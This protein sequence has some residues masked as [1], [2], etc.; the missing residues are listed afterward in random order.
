VDATRQPLV[1]TA[2]TTSE[3]PPTERFVIRVWLP[4]RPGALGAVASRIGAVGGDVTG[5]EIV[6]QGGGCAV[7][8]LAVELPSRQLDLTL[9][10]IR[11]VDE[12]RVESVRAI[13]SPPLDPRLGPLEAC[14]AAFEART[15]QQLAETLCEHSQLL[16]NG[17][18]A[19]VVC[20]TDGSVVAVRGDSPP[21][22]WLG[23]YALGAPR[24]P[25]PQDPLGGE[26]EVVCSHLGETGRT[27]V[28][29]RATTPLRQREAEIVDALTLV[30]TARW[31]EV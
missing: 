10:E 14:L 24:S 30:V 18:W 19:A 22:D 20:T 12:V 5:I 7:D 11:A 1:A 9:R 8:E 23:A 16:V 29:G 6:D 21:L 4:D 17:D 31:N 28:L 2:G 13:D 3:S 25:Y 27:L 26:G 15:H